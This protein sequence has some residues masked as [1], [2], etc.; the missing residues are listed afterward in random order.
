MRARIRA[1]SAVLAILG[2]VAP[3]GAVAQDPP[4]AEM[5]AAQART[6]VP[7]GGTLPLSLDEAV[8]R[9]LENNVDIAVERY[10]PELSAQNVISAEGYYDPFLFAN[11]SKTSTDTKGT[12]SFSGGDAVNTKTDVWNFGLGIPVQTGRR[13][14]PRLQQQQA[15]HQQR[16]HDLQPGLQLEPLDQPDPAAAQGLQDRRARGTSSGSPRRAARSPTCSS[17]RRSSTPSPR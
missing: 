11:L 4:A 10:N 16:L 3:T 5:A 17:A 2:L 15:G 14:Q 9:A 1:L 6:A 12:N 8:A 13:L 7:P